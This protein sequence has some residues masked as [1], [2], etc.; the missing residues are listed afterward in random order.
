[1]TDHTFMTGFGLAH[2]MSLPGKLFVTDFDGTLLK[3]DKTIAEPDLETLRFLQSKRIVTAIATGRSV[4]SFTKAVE[5]LGMTLGEYCLPVDYLIFSTGAG[6]IR[7]PRG[8]IIFKKC[9]GPD[10]IRKITGYFDSEKLDYMVHKPMPGTR[11][12]LYRTHGRYN[13]DFQARLGIYNGYAHQMDEGTVFS[14]SATQVLAIIPAPPDMEYIK[15]IRKKLSGYSV[16]HATSPLDHESAWIE[17]FHRQVSK[18]GAVA[19]LAE[20]LGICRSNV[21]AV[22][23]DYNDRDMLE[24][25]GKAFVVNNAPCALKRMFCNVSSNDECGVTDAAEKSGIL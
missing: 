10:D 14:E 20:N 4:Y 12:F 23:N 9:L 2:D 11:Y 17:V 15:G 25:S 22:G 16:I 8:D 18:A 3:S 5:S 7:F 13:P 19:F 24:W 1:L 21:I 6:I